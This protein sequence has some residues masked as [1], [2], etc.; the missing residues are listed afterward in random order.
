[1]CPAMISADILSTDWATNTTVSY[2]DVARMP[3]SRVEY[4]CNGADL[5]E[6]RSDELLADRSK[7][8]VVTCL[9]T[10]PPTWN[11]SITFPCNCKNRAK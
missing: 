7:S 1:M 2:M 6:G 9:D 11:D 3:G 10:S 5:Y 4:Q 8:G